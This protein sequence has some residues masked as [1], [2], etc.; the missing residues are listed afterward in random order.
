MGRQIDETTML[1]Y[2]T[3]RTQAE[4]DYWNEWARSMSGGEDTGE[5]D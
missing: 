1:G 4:I 2:V 5:V 3:A